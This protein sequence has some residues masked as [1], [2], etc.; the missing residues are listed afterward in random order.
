VFT[1]CIFYVII[2]EKSKKGKIVKIVKTLV[3]LMMIIFCSNISSIGNAS[4]SS[5]I[6]VKNGQSLDI[7]IS[8]Y[9][10]LS[11]GNYLRE[12]QIKIKEK[13]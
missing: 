7:L 13:E 9:F 5:N 11:F 12:K 6:N 10:L 3:F 8:G 2:E 1:F 4:I